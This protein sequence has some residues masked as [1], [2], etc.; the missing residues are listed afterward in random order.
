[1]HFYQIL[2]CM[3]ANVLLRCKRLGGFEKKKH[4]LTM[5]QMFTKYITSFVRT[6]RSE[7][8][9]CNSFTDKSAKSRKENNPIPSPFHE[10]QMR[11]LI[12]QH[13]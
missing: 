4:S 8:I 1:M 7:I 13:L 2:I 11:H 3:E 5:M 10:I 6:E 9:I 12:N